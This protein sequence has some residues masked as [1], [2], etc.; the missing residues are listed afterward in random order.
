MQE[1]KKIRI[2]DL[3]RAGKEILKLSDQV[4][5]E[6]QNEQWLHGV[7]LGY[8]QAKFG[9]MQ[10]E[11][12][13]W[14]GDRRRVDF[15]HAVPNA[16]LIELVVMHHGVEQSRKQN[17]TELRKLARVPPAR[18]KTRFLLILDNYSP[19]PMRE[20]GFKER[21]LSQ[22]V[23]R[24]RAPGGRWNAVRVIYVHRQGSFNFSWP[25]RWRS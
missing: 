16:V 20:A 24:G 9:Q 5:W 19:R 13:P 8:L 15:R 3:R 21:F 23:W 2:S 6:H 1:S 10:T 17:D 18:A 12:H 25:R 14:K 22:G 7:L 11:F 4:S